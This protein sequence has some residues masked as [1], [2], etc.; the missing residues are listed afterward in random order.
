[1]KL[2]ETFILSINEVFDSIK[3]HNR[4]KIIYETKKNDSQS[5]HIE[6]EKFRLGKNNIKVISYY[7]NNIKSK[8]INF[9]ILND[10]TPILY[11]Y[12]IINTYPQDRKSV[13]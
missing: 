3:I 12:N 5:I 8:D 2:D 13:V 7:K 4:D 9:I 1:M 6:L 11:T 10:K